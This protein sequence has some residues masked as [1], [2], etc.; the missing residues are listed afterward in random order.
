MESDSYKEFIATEIRKRVTELR[1]Q[2][3]RTSKGEPISLAAIG[4]TLDPPVSRI[5]V[6]NVVDGRAESARIKAAIEKELG[7]PYWIRK[8]E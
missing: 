7:R 3:K 6:Y 4:R 8:G 1:R 5:S 2:G